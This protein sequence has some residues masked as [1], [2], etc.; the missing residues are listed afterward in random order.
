MLVVTL[1]NKPSYWQVCLFLA[2]SFQLTS[3]YSI[4]LIEALLIITRISWM[5]YAQFSSQKRR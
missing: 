1:L 5:V 4:N 2:K 3:D